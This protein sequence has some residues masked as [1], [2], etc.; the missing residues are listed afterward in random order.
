MRALND[1]KPH[2]A[3]YNMAARD[4][5]IS[6]AIAQAVHAFDKTL[7]LFGLSGSALIR[8]GKAVGL[9]T[10][11]EVFADRTHQSDGSLTP[12]SRTDALIEKEDQSIG[13]VLQMLKEGKVT[14]TEGKEI[15]IV[16]ETICLHGDGKNAVKFAKAIHDRLRADNIELK[17]VSK[18][19]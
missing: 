8:E 7:L 5:A 12:R 2:G 19:K 3:L 6:N 11:S 14:T 15:S 17:S 10:V 13:Q 16:A 1:V 18:W 4:T 9:Q